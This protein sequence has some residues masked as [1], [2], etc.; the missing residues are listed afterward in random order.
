MEEGL[1]VKVPSVTSHCNKRQTCISTSLFD[2]LKCLF[3]GFLDVNR[4]DVNGCEYEY[5]SIRNN[6]LKTNISQSSELKKCTENNLLQR[7]WMQNEDAGHSMWNGHCFGCWN[8]AEGLRS[9]V[10]NGHFGKCLC[11]VIVYPHMCQKSALWLI[12]LGFRISLLKIHFCMPL[13]Q[14]SLPLLSSGELWHT[15]VLCL[16][17][18]ELWKA[19]E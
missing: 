15:K 14:S 6:A 2:T 19:E 7:H 18:T 16:K 10:K 3:G 9:W 13:M 17:Q 4:S 11:V 5:W 1:D 8:D 12:L